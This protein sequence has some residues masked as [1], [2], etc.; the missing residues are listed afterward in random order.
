MS[1]H[2]E[3]LVCSLGRL[4]AAAGDRP[5]LC[6]ASRELTLARCAAAV[7]G[8]A[9]WLLDLGLRSGDRVVL[10][11]ENS[12]AFSVAYFAIHAAGGIAVPH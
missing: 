12:V 9:R 3:P 6:D 5:G 1:A 10:F 4:A 2:T 7:R 11:G 8:G